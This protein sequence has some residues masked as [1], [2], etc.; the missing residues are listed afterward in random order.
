[1]FASLT[2]MAPG[3]QECR[4]AEAAHAALLTGSFSVERR[5]TLTLNGKLKVRKLVHL[6]STDGELT[7]ETLEVEKYDSKLVLEEGEGDAIL[8]IP[9]A[10]DRLEHLDDGSLR[11]TSPDGTEKV[12]F[13]WSAEREGALEPV[14]WRSDETARF[15]WKKFVIEAVAQYENFV[16]E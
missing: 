9:F 6:Q 13:A 2:M 5:F 3:A 4:D 8:E 16:W 1:M 10:C 14:S 7:R 11:L 12:V 15:L